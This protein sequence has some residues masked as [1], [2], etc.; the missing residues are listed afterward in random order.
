MLC[1]FYVCAC[2][3]YIR[4]L[5]REKTCTNFVVLEPPIKVFSTNLGMPYQPIIDFSFFPVFLCGMVTSYQSD[6]SLTE[7]FPNIWYMFNITYKLHVQY[8]M[9]ALSSG[10]LV[11]H[12]LAF[13][14]CWLYDCAYWYTLY[15][16]VGCYGRSAHIPAKRW[17]LHRIILATSFYKAR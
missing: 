2:I 13:L 12:V 5:L 1:M 9:N 3:L 11:S 17:I 6:S 16:L 10:G 14:P 8:V 4:K 7:K 15:I